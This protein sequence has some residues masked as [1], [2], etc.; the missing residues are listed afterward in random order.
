[1]ATITDEQ[2][3]EVRTRGYTIVPGFL[4]PELL[5]QARE[6]LWK[7]YPRPEDYFADP[8]AHAHYSRSQFAGLRLFPYP[9]W[10]LNRLAV[11]PDLVDGARRLCGTEDLHLYKVELWAKY[12][13]AVD[14]DQVHHYDYGNHSLVVPKLA[15]RHTQ[16]TCFI[17]LSDVT[18]ADGPTKVVPLGA[19]E[20]VP[21]VPREKQPGDFADEEVSITGSAGSL[22]IYKTTVLHRGSQFTEPN[23]SRF[24]LLVDFQPRGWMWTGKMAWP[25]QALQPAWTE[26]MEKMS[27]AERTLF[28]FPPPGDDY[29]DAQTVRD[30]GLRYPRMD[31]TPYAAAS[32]L[33]DV[34]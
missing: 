16:M 2:L 19:A 9:S 30:V 11:H 22:F 3:D 18:E 31:M 4:E 26:A 7:I 24:V 34:P 27:P 15:G 20:S 17:L 21:L 5:D 14:N 23:R 1:M 32:N 13:G 33:R 6:A 12:A 25:N 10:H 28:G 29:W 8:G